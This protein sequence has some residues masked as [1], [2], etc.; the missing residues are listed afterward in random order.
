LKELRQILIILENGQ[1][2]LWK[3]KLQIRASC[4]FMFCKKGCSRKELLRKRDVPL[5]ARR[6]K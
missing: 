3:V 6:V 5:N 1:Q 4:V 2:K